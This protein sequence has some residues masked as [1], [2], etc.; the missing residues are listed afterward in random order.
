MKLLLVI[1]KHIPG[2]VN[3]SA[4]TICIVCSECTSIEDKNGWMN[5][6]QMMDQSYKEMKMDSQKS[7]WTVR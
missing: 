6:K 3:H 7:K 5:Y 1:N 2:I 4:G